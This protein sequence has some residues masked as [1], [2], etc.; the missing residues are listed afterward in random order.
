MRAIILLSLGVVMS[1]GT[2]WAQA[3]KPEPQ[4][5]K[6]AAQTAKPPAPQT[7]KPPAPQTAK[8]PAPQTSKPAQTAKPAP[9]RAAQPAGRSGIAMTVVD[10]KGATIPDVT[11]AM[12]GPTPRDGVSDDSGQLN[13]PGLQAGTYRLRFSG[14][15]VVTFEREITLRAGQIEKF[16]VTLNS[17]PPPPPPPPP[18]P[19]PPKPVEP[20]PPVIGPTGR[21]QVLSLVDLLERDVITSKQTRKDTLVACSGNTRST[22]MQLNEP[23]GRRVYEAAEM[24]YYVIAGEGAINVDGRDVALEPGGYA[25]LPRGAP[26]SI[27]R[28]GR[29][30][31]I[32]LAVLSGER[33]EEAK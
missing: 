3:A 1:T 31:L 20:P 27:T 23:Q 4:T 18:A 7:A 9:P 21:P 10:P 14:D 8:P 19:E 28:K 12:T 22:L 5:A 15:A 13:F 25:A 24:L 33:C 17:A 2:S 6:P 29:R 32:L 30:P 11:V 16:T 26:H